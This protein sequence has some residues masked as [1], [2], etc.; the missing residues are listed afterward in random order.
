MASFTITGNATAAGQ[1]LTAQSVAMFIG[2]IFDGAQVRLE[3][4]PDNAK[5][6]PVTAD[7]DFTRV[8]R[9]NPGN[10][11]VQCVLP[12]GWYVRTVTTGAG[13]LTNLTVAVA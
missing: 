8:G 3:A 6:A 2:G 4:S 9:P 1:A 13:A 12:A 10:L 11:V 7:V 5:W